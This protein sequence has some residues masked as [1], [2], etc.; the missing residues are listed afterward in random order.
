MIG[1]VIMFWML[2][3]RLAYLGMLRPQRRPEFLTTRIGP[4][5]G[6]ASVA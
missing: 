1:I 5:G 3:E 4:D 2:V 6:L